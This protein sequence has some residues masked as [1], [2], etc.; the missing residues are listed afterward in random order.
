VTTLVETQGVSADAIKSQMVIVNGYAEAALGTA[1][2]TAAATEE[3]SASLEEISAAMDNMSR[4]VSE[5]SIEMGK[6]H[7]E[8]A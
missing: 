6:F 5:I 7:L 4:V 1:S 3:S 8:G 2:D